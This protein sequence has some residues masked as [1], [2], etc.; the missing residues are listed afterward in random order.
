MCQSASLLIYGTCVA[1]RCCVLY[2]C[3]QCVAVCC[4][5]L[6]CVAVC[7]S[8]L[9]CVAVSMCR[10]VSQCCSV[11][12]CAAVQCAAVCFRMGLCVCGHTPNVFV[13]VCCM[14]LMMRDTAVHLYLIW[15]RSTGCLS[16]VQIE[17]SYSI[18]VNRVTAHAYTIW[19][20]C[21]FPKKNAYTLW[22]FDGRGREYL[23]DTYPRVSSKR[24]V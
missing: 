21:F 20:L 17:N 2:L 7:C 16:Y 23:W 10:S 4:S 18:C 6:Q 8:V 12:Q 3:L 22:I 11:L 13:S 9:H 19:I 5:V 15:Q 1:V 24:Q 14:K